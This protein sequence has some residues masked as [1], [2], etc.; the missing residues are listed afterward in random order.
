MEDFKNIQNTLEKV[1]VTV[2]SLK[3]W[4]EDAIANGKIS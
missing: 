4:V 1:T 3:L 2:D